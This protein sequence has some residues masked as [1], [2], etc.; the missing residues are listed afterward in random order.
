M[1]TAAPM[2]I[3]M[4]VSTVQQAA[5]AKAQSRSQRAQQAQ[6]LAL[7]EEERKVQA[8]QQR[9]Q[10]RIEQ[11]RARASFGARGVSSTGGSANAL[12]D[13]IA[14]RTENAIAEDRRLFDLG[15][16][17][18]RANQ[19]ARERENLLATRNSIMST[20]ANTG[21]QMIASGF[22]GGGG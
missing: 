13:G 21:E 7:Q 14:S 10:S 8:D 2:L 4:A 20:V 12:V 17:A 3:A 9:E 6:Q 16:D 11:A 1:A 18:L 5:Q 19:R 15:A 22:G